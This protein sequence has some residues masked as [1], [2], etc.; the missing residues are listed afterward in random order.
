MTITKLRAHPTANGRRFDL[1]VSPEALKASRSENP[2]LPPYQDYQHTDRLD[3]F[4]V[5]EVAGKSRCHGM[6][7]EGM[8]Y[9]ITP[10]TLNTSPT[11]WENRGGAS[12]SSSLGGPSLGRTSHR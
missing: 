3:N 4:T 10:M 8:A 11:S 5:M 7:L 2:D 6:H 1:E 12:S 9:P